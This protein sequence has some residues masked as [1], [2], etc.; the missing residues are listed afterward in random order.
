M[1]AG[2]GTAE[3]PTRVSST[4]LPM[5][6]PASPWPSSAY[7]DG[8][9]TDDPLSLGEFGKCGVAVSSLADMELLFDGI[10]VTR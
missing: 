5:A 9:D 8:R 7:P 10:P 1:F 4:S 3:R 2:F 6:R